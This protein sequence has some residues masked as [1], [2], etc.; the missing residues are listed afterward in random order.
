MSDLAKKGRNRADQKNSDRLERRLK[1]E[2]RRQ[3]NHSSALVVGYNE[4]KYVVQQGGDQAACEAITNGA[5][6]IGQRVA[7]KGDL[8]D[9]MRKPTT[10]P[11]SPEVETEFGKIKYLYITRNQD[12]QQIL[13]AAGW[14]PSQF[15]E[16]KNLTG[17]T[18]LQAM[19]DNLGGSRYLVNLTYREQESQWAEL[20]NETG[21]SLWKVEIPKGYP[22]PS[23]KG[24]GFFL[25]GLVLDPVTVGSSFFGANNDSYDNPELCGGYKGNGWGRSVN[26]GRM[27]YKIEAGEIEIL[28]QPDSYST[29]QAFQFSNQCFSPV[30]SEAE[31]KTESQDHWEDWFSPS[32]KLQQGS[33]GTS[34]NRTWGR[35]AA[36]YEVFNFNS[37]TRYSV[38]RW[39]GD[40]KIAVGTA[41]K[42]EFVYRNAAISSSVT[43][44]TGNFDDTYG[45]VAS[46]EGVQETLIAKNLNTSEVFGPWK[47]IATVAISQ[48]AD[49][50]SI[51][52]EDA[53]LEEGTW[54]HGVGL[55]PGS[56]IVSRSGN[57]LKLNR[58]ARA[59]NSRV[60]LFSSLV[61]ISG[62][63]FTVDLNINFISQFQLAALT[64]ETVINQYSNGAN[65][66]SVTSPKLTEQEIEMTIPQYNYNLEYQGVDTATVYPPPLGTLG[67]QARYPQPDGSIQ[68]PPAFSVL[69]ASYHP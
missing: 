12:D 69:H 49:A 25:S 28:N 9:Q 59:T 58:P 33:Y 30:S 18:S 42:Q 2:K 22:L 1:Q 5:I 7:K 16:V 54:V 34:L 24:Y 17:V 13:C 36:F 19:I 45:V 55:A 60:Q 51:L 8:I 52:Q 39:N 43:L 41:T 29:S 63:N 27:A 48:G 23:P 65:L 32:I 15:Q 50:V 4:G 35:Y 56:V 40:L 26:T 20:I 14:H 11:I 6:T 67:F 61:G 21:T 46:E 3:S 64:Y 10:R 31:S 57:S 38:V 68:G 62:A 44:L 53:A 37:F 47:Q 66:V